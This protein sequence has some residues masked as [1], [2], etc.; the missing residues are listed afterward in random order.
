MTGREPPGLYAMTVTFTPG[1]TR[2]HLLW[3]L[4]TIHRLAWQL[5]GTAQR[6]PVQSIHVDLID[7]RTLG[8]SPALTDPSSTDVR[9]TPAGGLVTRLT[10]FVEPPHW[11]DGDRR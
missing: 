9:E 10:R 6:L 5:A 2:Q 4:R 7:P 1:I 8:P 3:D 11:S